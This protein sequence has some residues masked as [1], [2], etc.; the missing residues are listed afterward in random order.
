MRKIRLFQPDAY[1]SLD[2][3]RQ[4]GKIYWKDRNR[5]AWKNI[6]F[7]KAEPLKLEISSFVDCVVYEKNPDV[8]GEHGKYALEVAM[9]ILEV[10][11]K[12]KK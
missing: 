6:P 12:N 8:S 4:E 10:I 9:A 2:Y 1:I 3:L 7:E 5:I 11:K